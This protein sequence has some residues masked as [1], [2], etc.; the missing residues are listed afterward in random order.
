MINKISFAILSL[1][2]FAFAVPVF[3]A[4]APS[5]TQIAC[6]GSA[7]NVRET[8]LSAGISAYSQPISAAYSARA[9]ALKAAYSQPAGNGVIKGAVQ[10]AWQNFRTATKA[11]GSTWRSARNSAW[12]Q[13]KTSA[14]ACKAP[15][16][17]ND[18][19][20]AGLENAGQ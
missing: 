17:S 20:N 2:I 15:G 6:V 12:S 5:A 14:K 4:T 7:V 10:T 1:S 11:A 9:V 19:A 8:A 18:G 16:V 13:F 3:A